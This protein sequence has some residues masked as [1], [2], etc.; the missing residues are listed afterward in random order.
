MFNG[1]LYGIQSWDF[2]S[3][4]PGS[5]VIY[6]LFDSTPEKKEVNILFSCSHSLG[7]SC[8]GI[9]CADRPPDT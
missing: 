6:G 4:E 9:G 1:N 7:A 8:S 2:G 5:D 3:A